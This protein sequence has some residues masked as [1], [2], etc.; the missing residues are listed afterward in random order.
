MPFGNSLALSRRDK[1]KI[2]QRFNAGWGGPTRGS[3]GGTKEPS[4]HCPP[5]RRFFCRPCGTGSPRHGPPS[6]ETLGYFRSS[7]R[8]FRPAASSGIPE[9]HYVREALQLTVPGSESEDPQ[10]RFGPLFS[11]VSWANPSAFLGGTVSAPAGGEFPYWWGVTG[12]AKVEARGRRRLGTESRLQAVRARRTRASSQR[13]R[14]GE[15]PTG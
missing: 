10:P 1:V 2:A 11:C 15:R 8:D 12:G 4:H 13:A 9:R 3:P 14:H 5:A 6:V 7:L